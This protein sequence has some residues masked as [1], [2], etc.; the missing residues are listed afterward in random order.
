[1]KSKIILPY[2]PIL[3]ESTRSIG[4]S[5]ESAVADIIDNSLGKN[6]TEINVFFSAKEPQYVAIIDNGCGMTGE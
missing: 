2:A 5:F 1:M 3:I 6:A 4:Y